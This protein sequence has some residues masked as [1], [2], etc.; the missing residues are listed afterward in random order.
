MI[1]HSSSKV[2]QKRQIV[3][4]DSDGFEWS[5]VMFCYPRLW[6]FVSSFAGT[7]FGK[8]GHLVHFVLYFLLFNELLCCI[9]KKRHVAISL[10]VPFFWCFLCGH[11]NLSCICDLWCLKY[12]THKFTSWF[13]LIIHYRSWKRYLHYCWPSFAN[14]GPLLY[15]QTFPRLS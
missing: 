10:L 15:L 9:G 14:W 4:V 13:L 7:Y 8:Q 6:Y 3:L 11:G 2:V 5:F 1:F 12:G